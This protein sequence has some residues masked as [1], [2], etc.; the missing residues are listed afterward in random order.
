MSQVCSYHYC[1]SSSRT[2]QPTQASVWEV[3]WLPGSSCSH[4]HSVLLILG[5]QEVHVISK[6]RLIPSSYTIQ[7]VSPVL[8]ASCCT[9]PPATWFYRKGIH[10]KD[11]RVIKHGLKLGRYR[12]TVKFNVT[13]WLP[14]KLPVIQ[15]ME[16]STYLQR[17]SL[18]KKK[19]DYR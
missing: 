7:Y 1:R 18:H 11:N 5:G 2:A 17:E 8:S 12:F 4:C 6:E 3:S 15:Y 14:S 19:K 9:I 16:W 13:V 10:N